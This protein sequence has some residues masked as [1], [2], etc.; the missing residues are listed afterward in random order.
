MQSQREDTLETC[1][2]PLT[3][4]TVASYLDLRPSRT[5]SRGH[6]PITE[7]KWN[8]N[9][10]LLDPRELTMHKSSSSRSTPFPF[11]LPPVL[12]QEFKPKG[13]Q[14]LDEQEFKLIGR[15]KPGNQRLPDLLYD[16]TDVVPASEDSLLFRTTCRETW[17][18]IVPEMSMM[19]AEAG[20]RNRHKLAKNDLHTYDSKPLRM[21][22]IYDRVSCDDPVNGWQIRCRQTGHL[23]GFITYTKFMTYQPMIFHDGPPDLVRSLNRC[24]RENSY[25]FGSA[26]TEIVELVLLG[27][28]GCGTVL[29]EE[30]IKSLINTNVKY[31]IIH[32]TVHAQKYYEKLG[33]QRVKASARYDVKNKQLRMPTVTSAGYDGG[34]GF[35]MLL[36]QFTNDLLASVPMNPMLREIASRVDRGFL[37]SLYQAWKAFEPHIGHGSKMESRRRYDFYR[38]QYA[39]HE[40]FQI[41][42]TSPKYVSAFLKDP[43]VYPYHHWQFKSVKS[44]ELEDPSLLLVL[45]LS[46][47]SSWNPTPTISAPVEKWTCPPLYEWVRPQQAKFSPQTLTYIP[48]RARGVM[49]QFTYWYISELI[50]DLGWA[51]LIPL[52]EKGKFPAESARKGRTR[53]CLQSRTERGRDL[54]ISIDRLVSVPAECIKRSNDPD[55]DVWDIKT[56]NP[57]AYESTN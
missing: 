27:A 22:Y 44:S 28:L 39:V 37:T 52:V 17:K 14:A 5:A 29:M 3:N 33:F 1:D 40:E 16:V 54:S 31:V 41:D 56:F 23:Q 24:H 50:P 34:Y 51:H 21:D 42:V 12:N 4:S 30:F 18:S 57:K 20:W 38:T 25:W 48:G 45:D 47:W 19:S 36:L 11:E 49:S 35:H 43:A 9:R 53:Y 32:A 15:R 55:Q 26:W 7:K 10:R 13:V 6:E 8:E 2:T 46:D